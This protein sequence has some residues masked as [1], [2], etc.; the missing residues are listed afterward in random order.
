MNNFYRALSLVID[1]NIVPKCFVYN[2]KTF[3]ICMSYV[4]EDGSDISDDVVFLVEH[5][6]DF[7]YYVD[8]S[9]MT[10]QFFVKF[11]F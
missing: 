5:L 10:Q 7:I 11:V 1:F 3:D 8:Y 6:N 2:D 4:N 9:E